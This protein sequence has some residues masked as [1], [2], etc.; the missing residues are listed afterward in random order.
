[1]VKCHIPWFQVADITYSPI[2]ES[3]CCLVGEWKVHERENGMVAFQNVHHSDKWL[4]IIDGKTN[5]GV[6]SR[7]VS[8]A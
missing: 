4:R 5:C 3:L 7:T 8:E 1:M 2:C 6:S